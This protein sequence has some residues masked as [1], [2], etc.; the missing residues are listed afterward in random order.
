VLG[1]GGV[2]RVVEQDEA[3]AAARGDVEVV[4][5]LAAGARGGR[6]LAARAGKR[7]G[8]TGRRGVGIRANWAGRVASALVEGVAVGAGRA[9]RS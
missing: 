8:R 3:V 9:K 1:T 7:A 2:A 5:G 6:C 4:V